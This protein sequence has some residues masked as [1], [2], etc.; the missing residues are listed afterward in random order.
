[1]SRRSP[2]NA[3]YKKGQEPKGSTRKSAASAKPIRKDPAPVTKKTAAKQSVKE[4][5]AAT[6]P[7]SPEYKRLRRLWWTV[8]GIA[9]LILVISLILTTK[10]IAPQVGK[11]GQYI[12][13]A[14]SWIALGLVGFAWWV[15]LKQVRPLVQA[16]QLGVTVEQFQAMNAAAKAAKNTKKK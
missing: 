5:Y 13:L 6:M 16:H 11:W 14:M 4:R 10:S 7:D 3:R 9:V 2:M 8:L 12:S 1:M 15:D